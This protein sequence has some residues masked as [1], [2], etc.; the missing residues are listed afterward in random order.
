MEKKTASG[1]ESLFN[2]GEKVIAHLL[3]P[4]FIFGL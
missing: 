3:A 1:N 4:L 2:Y